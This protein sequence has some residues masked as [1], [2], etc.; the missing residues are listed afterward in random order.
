MKGIGII[1]LSV[2]F[3]LSVWAQSGYRT[4]IPSLSDVQGRGWRSGLASTY[5]RLPASAE[6]RVRKEVWNLSRHAAGLYLSFRTNAA[7][8]VVNY[9]VQGPVQM[10]HMP[11][12]GV[13][14][15]DLYV[16]N[17]S[18]SWDWAAGRYRFGDTIRYS[19]GTLDTTVEREYVLYLPLYNH[20]NWLKLKYPDGAVFTTLPA[21]LE[22]P[23]VVYGTSIAQGACATRPGLGWTSILSRMINRPVVNL[24]FS[25][26][27]RLEPEVYG[28]VGEIDASVFI[29]DCL[30]NMAGEAYIK[31]GILR[32]RLDSAY[33]FLR[34][35]HPRTPV[36]FTEHA[37]YGD[38]GTNTWKMKTYQTANAVLR[39]FYQDLQKK[40]AKQI[41]YL[42]RRDI[43]LGIES[44]VDG[45][46]PNDI[47]MMEYAEA[48]ARKLGV[49]LKK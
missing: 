20:V 18:D 4:W 47:G 3:S 41:G 30:P 44:T 16:K 31:E 17:G 19:F 48:Y 22:K 13:S 46:H 26:N 42:S 32:R 25:G 34:A 2:V 8:L 5:D 38:E 1:L 39:S 24:A 36:L 33:A 7:E 43:G 40:G 29:L 15:V 23:V 14:G 12:T 37:G 10:P 6:G 45:I 27:G 28:Y 9:T 35:R 21:A 49:M 11:A